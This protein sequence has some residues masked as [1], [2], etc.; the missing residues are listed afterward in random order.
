MRW[1][2]Q[3]VVCFILLLKAYVW[4]ELASARLYEPG[5]T[6]NPDCA[7]TESQCGIRTTSY[8]EEVDVDT[9]YVWEETHTFLRNIVIGTLEIAD[10]VEGGLIGEAVNTVDISS[11]ILIRQ[12]TPSQELALPSP[13]E[14]EAGKLLLITNGGSNSFTLLGS[15]VA[16]GMTKQLFW[17][18]LQWSIVGIQEGSTFSDFVSAV[19]E[20]SID[21]ADYLQEWHWDAL[22]G[23]TGLQL[24]FDNLSSG[25]GLKIS[26]SS[27]MLE[28]EGALL[29]VEGLGNSGNGALLRVDDTVQ[30]TTPFVVSWNGNV[31]V[32]SSN[33]SHNLDVY[34]DYSDAAI[35]ITASEEGTKAYLAFQSANNVTDFSLGLDKAD[36]LLKIGGADLATNTRLVMSN[37]GNLGLATT[38][39]PNGSTLS[40]GRVS[41]DDAQGGELAFAPAENSSLWFYMDS[42]YASGNSEFRLLEGSSSGAEDVR[43]Y[44]LEG[45]NG[46]QTPSDERIKLNI[47]TLE[48]VSERLAEVRAVRYDLVR[49]KENQIGVIAQELQRAFPEAVSI[50]SDGMLGV[51]YD[52]VAAIALQG[53]KELHGEI[54]ALKQRE[55]KTVDRGTVRI[56]AGEQTIRVQFEQEFLKVPVITISNH[57]AEGNYILKELTT[58][59]FVVELRESGEAEQ[60]FSWIAVE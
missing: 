60:T 34:A 50:R 26:S 25:K 52:S 59:G 18:G 2:N 10:L 51:N 8:L 54:E 55:T 6:L 56:S 27:N 33:P 4:P 49:G 12:D 31:G 22:T 16:P 40:L 44:I 29:L 41:E 43:A 15:V 57:N 19:S 14:P 5:E 23:G 39:L 20:H 46:W 47:E 9:E 35:G 7:P 36:G 53:V 13:T 17:N 58:D 3:L 24:V 38:Q 30:D 37:N 28:S 32:G 48:D 45:E 42:V 1:G 21:N 11:S